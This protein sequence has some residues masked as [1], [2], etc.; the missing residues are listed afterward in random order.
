MVKER[1]LKAVFDVDER[2]CLTKCL[3]N[4]VT[5]LHAKLKVGKAILRFIGR[6]SFNP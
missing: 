1:C 3:S 6:L 4:K 2:V 5:S